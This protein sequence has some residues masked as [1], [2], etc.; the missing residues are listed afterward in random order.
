MFAEI[1]SPEAKA[2]RGYTKIDYICKQAAKPPFNLKYCWVDTC[3]INKESS[4]ELS[5]AINSMFEWYRDATICYA[6]LEDVTSAEKEV[7]KKALWFT[8]GWTLQE[9]IAPSRVDFYGKDWVVLGSKDTESD[10]ITA[11]VRTLSE[12]TTIDR[13]VLWKPTYMKGKSIATRMSWAAKRKTTR[14]EDL[15]YSLMGLFDV[16]MPLL[17]GEGDKAFLRLQEEIIKNSDDHSI[18]AWDHISTDAD[19][20]SCLASF[21]SWFR[22]GAFV[23]PYGKKK[24]HTTSYAVTNIGLEI[25]LP[26][27]MRLHSSICY[28]L[29]NCHWANNLSGC[30]GMPLRQT[31]DPRV[32]ERAPHRQLENISAHEIAM[33]KKRT[34]FLTMQPQVELPFAAEVTLRVFDREVKAL[35][36]RNLEILDNPL[37]TYH[38]HPEYNIFRLR[39]L[40][41]AQRVKIETFRL[42]WRHPTSPK[43]SVALR[44]ACQV[45]N[46]DQDDQAIF[47]ILSMKF[48]SNLRISKTSDPVDD[49][50]ITTVESSSSMT[51][52]SVIMVSAKDDDSSAEV[53]LSTELIREYIFGNEVYT[54]IVK[55]TKT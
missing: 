5:E 2:K 14:K 50:S 35:G 9:L 55:T 45:G 11:F 6:Y 54:L 16:N 24:S 47:E 25:Q 31:P 43:Q 38:L 4:A 1:H 51:S 48:E 20:V 41:H 46:Q 53:Q 37:S 10:H 32:F 27:L 44:F 22:R 7:L 39:W 28:G 29:I 49:E 12:I 19:T 42:L 3:C 52:G 18:F 33:S 36:F 40:R 17:Y 13:L 23:I 30:I 26:I 34:V 8:R 15:A 21:P